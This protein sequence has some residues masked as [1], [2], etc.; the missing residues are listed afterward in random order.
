MKKLVPTLVHKLLKICHWWPL[1]LRE[2]LVMTVRRHSYYDAV[3]N[4]I[5][6]NQANYPSYQYL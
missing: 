2:T 1:C 5:C 6:T 3:G 4:Y